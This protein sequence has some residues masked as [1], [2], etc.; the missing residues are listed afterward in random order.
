VNELAA[1]AGYWAL[2]Q[3]D[4]II[5]NGKTAEIGSIGTMATWADLK[6]LFEKQGVRFHEVYATRSTDKNRMFLDANEGNYEAMI[7]ELD[8]VNEVFLSAIQK[9]RPQ[10]K[11]SALTGKVY[12]STEAKKLGLIDK[13][14]TFEDAIKA[15][16][17]R[18]KT[19]KNTMS[20]NS[21]VEQY[22]NVCATLG[23]ENGFE[24]T[25][26]G[27]FLNEENL[28]V[29]E[30]ALGQNI[31]LAAQLDAA[32]ANNNA[33]ETALQD[34]ET[35]LTTANTSLSE[36]QTTISTLEARIAE[37]EGKRA[38]NGTPLAGANDDAEGEKK[39]AYKS[40]GSDAILKASLNLK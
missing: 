29:V 33:S 37:L 25:E 14:G 32:R 24:S 35:A 2:S 20:K 27:V 13:I 34:A 4:E 31:D 9:A 26:Q 38:G 5:A 8:S 22:P 15:I 17:N 30:A 3:C 21:T 39:T 6:P 28:N 16:Q 23:F 19:T 1:S 12:L 40:D 7:Q 10:I 36:A 11:E 18:T